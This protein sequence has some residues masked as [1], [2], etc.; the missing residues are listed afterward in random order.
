MADSPLR[1]SPVRAALC[2]R[3]IKLKLTLCS[4]ILLI[5]TFH[6][7]PVFATGND[8][9]KNCN[10]YTVAKGTWGQ[11]Y[12]A[13]LIL[14]VSQTSSRICIPKG[15]TNKQKILVVEKYL[16]NTPEELH[17]SASSLAEH[18]LSLVWPCKKH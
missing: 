17:H 8:L 11:G 5:S 16:K 18:A 1:G 9:L 12:C 2:E 10:D 15:V 7:S 6:S 14:G 3:R 4:T 13:G